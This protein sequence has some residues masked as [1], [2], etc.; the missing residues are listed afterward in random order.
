VPVLLDSA[1]LVI[2]GIRLLRTFRVFE[3]G[4]FLGGASTTA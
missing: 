1:L 3:L 4:R 2:R